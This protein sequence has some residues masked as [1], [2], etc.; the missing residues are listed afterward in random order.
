MEI[1]TTRPYENLRAYHYAS[2]LSDNVFWITRTF[3]P[4]EH[5]ALTHT[6]R[7]EAQSVALHIRLG[8]NKRFSGHAFREHIGE[9]LQACMRLTRGL[10]VAFERSYLDVEQYEELLEHKAC[11]QRTVR[12]LREQRIALLA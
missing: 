4:A 12:R 9:A 10:N 1:N 8:W 6:L 7:H 3:P 5:D 11:V 2:D